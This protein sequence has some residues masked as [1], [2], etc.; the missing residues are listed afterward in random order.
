[1]EDV[2]DGPGVTS[3]AARAPE[4]EPDTPQG[5]PGAARASHVAARGS[6]PGQPARG[7]QPGAA[8]HVA[9]SHVA[10]KPGRRRLRAVQSGPGADRGGDAGAGGT[11]SGSEAVGGSRN[12]LEAGTRSKQDVCRSVAFWYCAVHSAMFRKLSLVSQ[13]RCGKHILRPKPCLGFFP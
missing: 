4:V 9:A 1:M 3:P 13:Q 5:Q 10:A 2:D 7:S 12:S 11:A 6:Q 8:S